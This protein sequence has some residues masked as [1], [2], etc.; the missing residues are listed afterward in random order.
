M[1]MSCSGID[2]FTLPDGSVAKVVA[3]V[4][5]FK[6]SRFHSLL[7][8]FFFFTTSHLK[9]IYFTSVSLHIAAAFKIHPGS[10]ARPTAEETRR[11]KT[12]HCTLAHSPG[13]S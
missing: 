8:L 6:R 12:K 2:E 1:S 9:D 13:V 10:S 3:L 4:L 11:K 7:L 5:H